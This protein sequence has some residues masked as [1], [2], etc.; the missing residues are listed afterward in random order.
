MVRCLK[1]VVLKM[2]FLGKS[3]E[4]FSLADVAVVFYAVG[5]D[6]R[7]FVINNNNARCQCDATWFE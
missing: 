2:P 5:I 6:H 7:D 4:R 1:W 3:G